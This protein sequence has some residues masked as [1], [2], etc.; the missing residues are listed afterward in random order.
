MNT[1]SLIDSGILQGL[2]ISYFKHRG[3]MKPLAPPPLNSL[4]TCPKCPPTVGTASLAVLGQVHTR[5]ACQ[6]KKPSQQV[7]QGLD[8]WRLLN[9]AMHSDSTL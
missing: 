5:L 4:L 1:S 7:N 8:C 9:K 3:T 2:K 6:S